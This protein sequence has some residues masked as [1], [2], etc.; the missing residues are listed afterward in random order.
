MKQRDAP[1]GAL[2][3]IKDRRLVYARGY[4][5]ADRDQKLEVTPESLFRIAS[6]SK[7]ITAVA[8]LKLAEQKKLA[9]DS[10]LFELLSLISLGRP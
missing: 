4:G 1:G 7:P 10:H 3:V 8:I 2:A 9:L 6:V 5:W